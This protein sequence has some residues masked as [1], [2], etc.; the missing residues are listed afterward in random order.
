IIHEGG[1][2]AIGT[3]TTRRH[4]ACVPRP[5][6]VP[7]SMPVTGQQFVENVLRSGLL[8]HDS[9]RTY[10]HLDLPTD[11]PHARPPLPE[12]LIADRLITPFQVRQLLS[13]KMHGYFLEGKYKILD[14]L[15]TGGMG[16]VFLCEH[17]ALQRL[18]AVKILSRAASNQSSGGRA[19]AV[20]RF[21]R[22]A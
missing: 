14:L 6:S 2:I 16:Q 10:L 4:S 17:L 8:T 12:R 20:E 5:R 7:L 13:G 18:V 22:E 3:V 19:A 15:G 11:G 21:V 1:T 9:L